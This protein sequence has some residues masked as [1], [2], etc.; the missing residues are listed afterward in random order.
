MLAKYISFEIYVEANNREVS[1][2]QW[3]PGNTKLTTP[4]LR[5]MAY[6][7]YCDHLA[8][9]KSTDSWY[10]KHPTITLNRKSMELYIKK[11]PDELPAEQMEISKSK[12]YQRWEQVVEDS[13]EGK[14]RDA[15]TASLQMLM[16]NKFGWDKK[17]DQ[18][19]SRNITVNVS[20]SGLASGANIST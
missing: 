14:N 17:D 7:Q 5:L 15:N 11:Y 18:N 1:M 12:G 20:G 2:A 9:G 16:R 19:D 13:A 6:T 3:E 10:F 4:E 8:L